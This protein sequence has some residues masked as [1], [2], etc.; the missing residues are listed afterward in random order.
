MS[1]GKVSHDSET[2]AHGQQVMTACA[3]IHRKSDGVVKVFLPK[4]AKTKRFLPGIYELPGGHIDFGEDIVDGLKREIEE[5]L[6]VSIKVGAPFVVREYTNEV[7]GS[8][9]IEAIYFATLL[10]PPESIKL[11]PEDHSDYGWFA[12]DDLHKTVG[13]W[14]A[15]DD[16]EFLAVYEAFRLLEGGTLDFGSTR[17]QR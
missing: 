5:E 15:P 14:G 9:S 2:P 16:P 10:D 4:R 12:K 6:G 11:H 13:D 17:Q 7:K 1:S 3:L 8:Q